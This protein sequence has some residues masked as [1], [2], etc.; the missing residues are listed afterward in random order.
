MV[1]Y[2][3]SSGTNIFSKVLLCVSHESAEPHNIWTTV[4]S[5]QLHIPTRYR[6]QQ[7][8]NCIILSAGRAKLFTVLIPWC[9]LYD[10][11][12]MLLKYLLLSDCCSILSDRCLVLIA[13]D[14]LLSTYC[15]MIAAHCLGQPRR[16]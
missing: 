6:L 16:V 7:L 8:H 15:S 4:R 1:V 2:R 3:C 11:R 5:S 9:S 14:I 10:V 13:L 12:C